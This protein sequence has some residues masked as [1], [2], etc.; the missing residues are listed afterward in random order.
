MLS[1]ELIEKLVN[2]N[3]EGTE[4]FLVDVNVTSD[5]RIYVYLDSDEDLTVSDCIRVS[6][7]IESN[8][9]RD[10][11]DFELLV[12]S[13]GLDRGFKV[14]RQYIKNIGREI[15]VILES[16]EKKA[17]ILIAVDDNE[18]ELEVLPPDNKKKKITVVTGNIKLLL[19]D[20]KE[21]KAVISFKKRK[22]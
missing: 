22:K 21:T 13:S 6:R 10:K 15:Q 14:K 8:L 16:G 12:S 3:L 11:E 17:G 19:K 9:D 20:I 5:S 18:I 4:K 1:V 2:Q 7:Y